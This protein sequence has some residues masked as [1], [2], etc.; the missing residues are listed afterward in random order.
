MKNDRQA[1]SKRIQ[2]IMKAGAEL[3]ST[4]GFV[5]TSMDEV[6]AAAKI[7]KG[8][9][10]HYFSSKNE[11]LD[12]ILVN[13][14][15]MVLADL[16]ELDRIADP[17]G[18]LTRLV[19]R[20]VEIYTKHPYAA[21]TLIDEAHCLPA[22]SRKKIVVKEKEYFRAVA[23]VVSEYLGPC[24]EKSEVTAITFSLLGMC[25]W[26]YSWYNPKG[27]IDPSRLSEIILSIF[28]NGVCGLQKTLSERNPQN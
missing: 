28:S 4:K 11:L 8:G 16:E 25:N 6:A 9:M 21:K 15:D 23:G 24:V 1:G 18:K 13:F 12:A 20:H 10:Y 27:P 19:S 5:E 7:S 17:L 22:R 2:S 26:I 14:I 3:F